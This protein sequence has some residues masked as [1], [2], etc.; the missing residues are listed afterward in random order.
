MKRISDDA[1]EQFESLALEG[2]AQIKAFFASTDGSSLAYQ[3][4]KLG[5]VAIS[6]YAK[7]RQSETGQMAIE[8]AN[9][10]LDRLDLPERV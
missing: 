2:V 5:G 10:R 1:V 4:A 7:V 9:K 6:G 8:L 3:K